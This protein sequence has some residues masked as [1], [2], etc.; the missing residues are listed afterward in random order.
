MRYNPSFMKR[1]VSVTLIAWLL[2][3]SGT[4]GIAYHITDVK[5]WQPFPFG[6][7]GILLIRVL[8]I[9]AGIYMLRGS[10]WARWVALLWIAFHLAISFFDDWTKVGVHAVVL[11][12]FCYILL[13]P[14]ATAYFRQQITART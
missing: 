1:P 3:T 13:R 5:N 4:A 14:A 10:N 7:F 11:A 2:I 6:Y 12:I 9:V 8:A